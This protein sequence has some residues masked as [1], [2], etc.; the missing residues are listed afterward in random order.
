MK[1]EIPKETGASRVV[2]IDSLLMQHLDSL[3]AYDPAEDSSFC[4]LHT[5]SLDI[6]RTLGLTGVVRWISANTFPHRTRS[7]GSQETHPK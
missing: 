2:D 6:S 7:D 5:S 4:K 3:P 1:N